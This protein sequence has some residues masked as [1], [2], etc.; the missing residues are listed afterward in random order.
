[1]IDIIAEKFSST[2]KAAHWW[3]SV[4]CLALVGCVVGPYCTLQ[5][6]ERPVTY[7]VI[8]GSKTFYVEAGKS[9]NELKTVYNYVLGLAADSMLNRSPNGLDNESLAS[10]VFS[11]TAFKKLMSQVKSDSSNYE[12][13]KIHQKN[14]IITIKAGMVSDNDG[15]AEVQGMILLEGEL[16]QVKFT[17]SMRYTLHFTFQKNMNFSSNG[18]LPFLVTSFRLD[19]DKD[20][21]RK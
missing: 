17:K 1:M 6:M 19:L 5:L 14:E 4:A 15:Q 20:E 3:F 21:V 12:K 10:Q 13:R 11:A 9:L 2:N 18:R 8:D 7:V 16:D